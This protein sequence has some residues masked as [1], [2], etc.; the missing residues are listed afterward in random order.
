MHDDSFHSLHPRRM[1]YTYG[2]YVTAARRW[3]Q[4]AID[5]ETNDELV[6]A[7]ICVER[8]FAEHSR[9]PDTLSELP[10][11]FAGVADGKPPHFEK[12]GTGF[13]LSAEGFDADK[14]V[15][16]QTAPTP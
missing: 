3:L 15:K 9:Y 14:P 2:E 12:T 6:R 8:H 1:F 13:L 5:E 10:E 11:Q 16:F 4:K 7:A